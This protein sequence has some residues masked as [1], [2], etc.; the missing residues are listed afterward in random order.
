MA[1]IKCPE[2]GREISDRAAN[3]PGC[4]FPIAEEIGKL[5]RNVSESEDYEDLEE[6]TQLFD[7]VEC[8]RPLPVGIKECIYCN[9]KYIYTNDIKNENYSQTGRFGKKNLIC[10][11]CGSRNIQVVNDIPMHK[12]IGEFLAFGTVM[13]TTKNEYRDKMEYQCNSCHNRWK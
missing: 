8:G 6:N 3:C 7:C 2:C 4:G 13:P 9:H 12:K 5:Q 11:K 1:L 10:P